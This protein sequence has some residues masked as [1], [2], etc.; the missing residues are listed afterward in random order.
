M[1]SVSSTEEWVV[2]PQGSLFAKCWSPNNLPSPSPTPIILLHDS[3][4]SVELWRDFPEHL[5]LTTGRPIIAY[6]RLGFGQ[7]DPFPGD[8]PASFIEDEARTSF[9]AVRE[10]FELKQFILFGHSVGGGMATFCAAAFPEQC[11]AVITESAQAFV[12]E[13]TLA[14]IRDAD[15]AFAREGMGRLEKYHGSK[16]A[17][18]LNAWVNTWLSEEFRD[19][20]LNDA[21]PLVRCPLLAIHGDRDEY[22]SVD[23]PERYASLAGGPSRK[24]IIPDCGHVP[25]R[26]KPDAVIQAVVGFLAEHRRSEPSP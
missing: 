20:T 23:Q 6:D 24:E 15:Q 26:E 16:A 22:G 5:A 3:L 8:L 12:E 7:S 13:R 10:Y 9:A 25:H 14:G 17:W 19:W 11:L 18:V 1:N 2:S 21:L 4:G